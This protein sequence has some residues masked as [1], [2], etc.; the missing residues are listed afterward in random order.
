MAGLEPPFAFLRQAWFLTLGAGCDLNPRTSDFA[1]V[2]TSV[3]RGSLPH[4]DLL[5]GRIVRSLLRFASATLGRVTAAKVRLDHV[6]GH[7]VPARIERAQALSQYESAVESA[8][9]ATSKR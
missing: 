8:F 2:L 1:A 7:A 4:G 3:V 6:A 9:S 5:G